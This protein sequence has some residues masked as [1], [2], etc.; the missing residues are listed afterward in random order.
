MRATEKKV[1][2]IVPMVRR[3]RRARAQTVLHLA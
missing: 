2:K 3:T 1:E